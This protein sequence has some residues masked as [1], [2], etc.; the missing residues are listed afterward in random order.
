MNDLT[1]KEVDRLDFVHNAIHDLLC[2]LAGRD[3]EWDISVISEISDLSEEYICEK[4]G[5][6]TDRE[7][8]PYVEG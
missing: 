1:D 5:L 6:M 7:F 4:L 8:A 3:I 2:T